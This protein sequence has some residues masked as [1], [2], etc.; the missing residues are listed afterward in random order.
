[1]GARGFP[2]VSCTVSARMDMSTWP[3]AVLTTSK[4]YVGAAVSTKL[5]TVAT[6]VVGVV[7]NVMSPSSKVT[8]SSKVIV[9][10]MGEVDVVPPLDTVSEVKETVGGVVSSSTRVRVWVSGAVFAL[11]A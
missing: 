6:P 11:S 4:V 7:V 1:M 9:N 3:S 8:S 10:G 5:E 2:A